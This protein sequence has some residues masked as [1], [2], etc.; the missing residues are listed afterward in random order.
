M[1]AAAEVLQKC[2]SGVFAF[3]HAKRAQ[4]LFKAVQA[5]LSSRRLVLMDMARAWP[6]ADRVRAPLKCLDRLLSNGHLHAQREALYS[7][8]IAWLIRT[9]EPVIVVDWTDLHA[10]CRWCLLRAAVPMGSR[11][12]TLLDMVFPE[13]MK[14]SAKAEQQLLKQLKA[15]LPAA[16][17]PILVTDAGFRAPWFQAVAKMGWQSVGR[18]RNTTKIKL[19]HGPWMDNRKFLPRACHTPKRFNDA[20]IVASNPW[21]VDLVLYRKKRAGRRKLNRRNGTRCRSHAS[22]QAERREREPWLL[23][24]STGLS[25]LSARQIVATY[26]KR[27]QIEQSFRDLKCDRFGYGFYY[28]LTRKPERIATLLL[29]QALAGFITWLASFSTTQ[30]T[31]K[32]YGGVLGGRS[33]PHYSLFRIACE[34]LRCCDP[35]FSFRVL[36]QTFYH[37][38]PQLLD[39]QRVQP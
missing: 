9:P 13:S 1:P 32:R 31:L 23:V 12:V 38:P 16:V 3:M 7:Q 39:E 18:L 24:V 4:A 8:M 17:K 15:L 25:H 21:Q 19:A 29:I 30:D 26:A 37:P 6:G 36:L 28:S 14:A 27:M 33:R 20:S 5:L 35:D 2:L 22:Q 11:T 34:A 10:D